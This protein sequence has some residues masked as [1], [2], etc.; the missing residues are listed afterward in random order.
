MS[1]FTQI[2]AVTMMSLATMTQRLGT[3]L[4]IVAGTAGVVAVIVSI[5]ALASGLERTIAAAGRD[6]RVVVMYRGAQG[7]SGSSL[8]RE[9]VQTILDLEGIQRDASDN[10]M[11]S[12]D[13]LGSVWLTRGDKPVP[14]S[15]P[16]RG[17]T[18]GSLSL[19]PEI[20]LIDGRMFEP[21][22]KQLI[23]GAAAQGRY[24]GLAL[25]DRIVSSDSEWEV[26]GVF[27]SGGS[28]HESEIWSDA[29][30]VLSAFH[31]NSFNSVTAWV[32]D[33]AGLDR[34]KSAAA[35]DPTLSIDIRRESDFYKD[36]SNDFSGFL[37]AIANVIGTIMAIGAVF[38]AINAMYTAV[39]T[40]TG[41]IATLRAIGFG[42]T[43]IVISVFVEAL[44]LAFI[45]ALLGAALAW[46][47]FNGNTVSTVSG[48]SGLSQ[49]VFA[50]RIGPDA[51]LLGI[52]WSLMLGLVGGLFPAIRAARLP[53]VVALRGA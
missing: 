25:G 28:V 33:A 1:I 29:E 45:G 47:F 20:A 36:Q 43:G 12:A 50:L 31:R 44:L 32:G 3:S 49:I 26:V 53:V 16:L 51:V 11:A 35:N 8:P 15:V 7:E 34:L 48:D 9:Q 38:G 17:I 39:S 42:A 52:S 22:L 46:L 37:S 10:L 5:L 6:E 27:T 4:V 21:G 14:A 40:R 30:S 2:N 24:A 23:V 41:E 18:P 13:A 19:R